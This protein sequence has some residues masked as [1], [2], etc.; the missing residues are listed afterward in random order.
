MIMKD[1]KHIRRIAIRR[2]RGG[3]LGESETANTKPA[4]SAS[5]RRKLYTTVYALSS[6][7]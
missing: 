3:Y 4:R 5:Q 1:V 6:D 2:R 7:V